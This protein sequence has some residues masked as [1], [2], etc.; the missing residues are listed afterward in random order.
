MGYTGEREDSSEYSLLQ[1]GRSARSIDPPYGS[2]RSAR[3][4]DTGERERERRGQRGSWDAGEES[5]WD[6]G[7]DATERRGTR[8]TAN[9]AQVRTQA[10][11]EFGIL[12]NEVQK[13]T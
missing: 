11:G 7:Y 13:P 12:A 1:V 5:T 4:L 6:D 3:S 10:G 2:E 8:Q 9:Q